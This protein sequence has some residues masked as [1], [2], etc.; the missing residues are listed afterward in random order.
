MANALIDNETINHKRYIH[1]WNRKHDEAAGDE[2]AG[3]EAAGD[4]AA[5]DEAAED[6][7]LV[8]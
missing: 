6:I 5:G 3:D 1:N 8:P 4:E 7:A 2:A